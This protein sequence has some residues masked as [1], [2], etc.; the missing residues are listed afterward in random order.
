MR[1][2]RKNTLFFSGL[3]GLVILAL[4]LIGLYAFRHGYVTAAQSQAEM[5]AE[6]VRIHLTEA[7]LH[8]AIDKRGRFLERLQAV[9]GLETVRIARGPELIAQ[10]GPGQEGSQPLDVVERQV[11]DSGR[12]YFGLVEGTDDNL[13]RAT[14]PYK[15]GKDASS[16]CLTCH[17]V[18]N[19]S[20]LG[21][22]SLSL[23][24][25]EQR[26]ETAWTIGS[27]V[28][29]ISFFALAAALLSQRTALSLIATAEQV[30]EAVDKATRGN[31]G[32]RIDIQRN[33]ELGEITAGVNRLL[34]HLSKGLGA[35]SDKVARLIRY[36]LPPSDNLLDTTATM[37]DCL[38]EVSLFKQA[39]EED[40]T[41]EEI[42]HRLSRVLHEEFLIDHFSI[43]EVD[44]G[45]NH[46]APAIIDGIPG[47]A[48]RWCDPEILQR[49]DA[50]RAKRT[51]HPVDSGQ[52]TD[53]CTSFAACGELPGC[54]HVCIPI[55]QSGAVGGVVQLVTDQAQ[56]SLLYK[57]Q[58]FIQVYLRESAPVLESKRLM[59]SLR[60]STLTDPMTGLH[61][62]RF[63]QEY[64]DTLT[65]YTHRR[66]SQFAVL[67][68]DLDYFKQVNDTYGH[69]AGDAVLKQLAKIL[70]ESVRSSDLVIRYGGEEFLLILRDTAREAADATAEKIRVAVENQKI[71]IAGTVINKTISIGVAIYPEDS[72]TFWQVVKYADV[73][74]YKAKEAGR[75]QILH[76]QPEMWEGQG[77]Y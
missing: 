59:A 64:S 29:V 77:A 72:G 61:N 23:S 54:R 47:S 24:V 50:C 57:M 16:D 19:G 14:I 5:A 60:A 4:L 76:F 55:I 44:P 42:Y 22:I 41:T 34:A 33:D 18:K 68:A 71:Q 10:Y 67:M 49:A 65:S 25:T 36:D 58:P 51:G 15:A 66:Q 73:A 30:H 12:P 62:R 48:C 40:E 7:M 2:S 26:R 38:E 53:I 32:G 43:Y 70:K 75:N 56:A 1:L 27:I 6:I 74:L 31:Y 52:M 45:K 21:A 13:F 8:G 63:L 9:K 3:A 39:I 28:L 20:V 46:M 11:I 35:I 17:K 37:V 69:E